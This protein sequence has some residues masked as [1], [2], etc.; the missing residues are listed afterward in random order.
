MILSISKK[1]RWNEHGSIYLKKHK[2]NEH[3]SIYLK[4]HTM[5]WTWF[6]LSQKH[7]D[8]NDS[9][10][11]TQRLIGKKVYKMSGKSI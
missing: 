4:T 3:Y 8:E 10:Y 5:K 1:H 2:W 9:I 11:P 7:I 6:Y